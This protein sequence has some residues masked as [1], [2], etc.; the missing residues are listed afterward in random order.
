MWQSTFRLWLLDLHCIWHI[1]V[2]VQ[3]ADF[4]LITL[5][6]QLSKCTLKKGLKMI[7]LKPWISI[8]T[9]KISN[10]LSGWRNT[11]RN[12]DMTGEEL[13]R[14]RNWRKAGRRGKRKRNFRKAGRRGKR[15]RNF[16]K[17]GGSE[18]GK[19]AQ[20]KWQIEEGRKEGRLGKGEHSHTR[21][22]KGTSMKWWETKKR[23]GRMGGKKSMRQMKTLG[24]GLEEG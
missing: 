20:G 8:D 16:R 22:R 9:D 21:G 2:D 4:Y 12:A 1:Y 17:A 5:N 24:K 11:F 7:N 19:R 10:K 23:A 6:F 14:E 15:K 3:L 13:E 18:T